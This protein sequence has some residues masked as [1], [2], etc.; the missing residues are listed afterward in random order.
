MT[1][2]ERNDVFEELIRSHGR[3]LLAT[4]RRILRNDEEAARDA[5]QDAFLSAHQS[6]PQFRGDASLPTWLH[7]IVVNAALM[8]RRGRQRR[9][10]TPIEDLLPTFSDDAHHLA[11]A[12]PPLRPEGAFEQAE[13]RN[14][15]RASIERLPETYRVVLVLR[16]LEELTTQEAADTLGISTNA[17]KVRLHRARQALM[18]LMSGEADVETRGLEMAVSC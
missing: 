18:T 2:S 14:A 15:V 17:V 6:L 7:R 8:R 10:E 1:S 16:D 5:V 4:A 9:R 3:R 11:M 13:L 12:V